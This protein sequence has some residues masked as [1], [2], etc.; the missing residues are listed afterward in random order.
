MNQFF[1]ASG[2]YPIVTDNFFDDEVIFEAFL[3]YSDKFDTF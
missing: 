1:F 2:Q 3:N